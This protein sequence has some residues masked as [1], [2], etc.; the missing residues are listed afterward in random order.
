MPVWPGFEKADR[1]VFFQ[2]RDLAWEVLY[3]LKCAAQSDSLFL[4]EKQV[5]T[6][7]KKT[8]LYEVKFFPDSVEQ[9]IDIYLRR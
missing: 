2:N 4:R 3:S 5:G 9:G 6:E 8:L 1:P 7:S